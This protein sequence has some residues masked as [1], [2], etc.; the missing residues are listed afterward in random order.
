[1]TSEDT[2]SLNVPEDC[3][4]TDFVCPGCGAAFSQDSWPVAGHAGGP[5]GGTAIH[6]CPSCGEN[7]V[8]VSY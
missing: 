1:M 3:P 7:A 5:W 6:E 8:T 2:L 4:L